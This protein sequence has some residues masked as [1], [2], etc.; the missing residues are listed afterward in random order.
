[1]L[2]TYTRLPCAGVAT[3]SALTAATALLMVAVYKN[4]RHA[5]AWVGPLLMTT[6][7]GVNWS[8]TTMSPGMPR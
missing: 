7:L 2:P 3:V 8:M 6:A 5:T 4:R 1:M